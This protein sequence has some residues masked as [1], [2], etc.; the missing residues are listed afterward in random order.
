[1]YKRGFAALGLMA[2][3]AAPLA[4]QA[5]GTP[6]FNAPYRAFTKHE[7]GATVSFPSG[8]ADVG[9]EGQYR[10]GYQQFDL[11]W[12]GGIV[13]YSASGVGGS[14][15]VVV[16][17]AEGRSRLIEH[18]EDFPLD[19]AVIVGLG[20]NFGSGNSSALIVGGLSLGRRIDPADTQVSIIPYAEPTLF[21]RSGN[22]S[23]DLSFAFG[24]G[25]DFRLSRVFDARVSVGLGDLEGVSFSAVWVH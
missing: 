9:L 12:R 5:A 6:S 23:T 10:F 14:R 2:G 21:I 18:T 22:S 8:A 7:F 25:A 13:S 15:T 11:G 17:G 19:G 20:G 24:L 16:I 4:G 1:M 3:C